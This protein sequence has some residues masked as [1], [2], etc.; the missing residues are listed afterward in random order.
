MGLYLDMLRALRKWDVIRTL[1]KQ[2][3]KSFNIRF[4]IKSPLW[5]KSRSYKGTLRDYDNFLRT[6]LSFRIFPVYFLSICFRYFQR[7]LCVS[8]KDISSDALVSQRCTRN[9]TGKFIKNYPR[10]TT[11]KLLR[12]RHSNDI[13]DLEAEQKSV[14]F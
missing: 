1:T 13:S 3:A 4:K 5:I 12:K 14:T 6:R 8:F 10:Y 2:I 7:H 9:I 11:G